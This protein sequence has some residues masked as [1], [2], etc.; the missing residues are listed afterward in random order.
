M[1]R[2][3]LALLLTFAASASGAAP[4]IAS[5]NMCTDQLLLGLADPGQI[6]GI[7]HLS[8]E[9]SLSFYWREAAGHR[10]LSGKAEDVL[11]LKPDVVLTATLVRSYTRG[12][13]AMQGLR[14]EEFA[15]ASTIA[16]VRAQIRRAGAL[17]GQEA[18]AE[19]AITRIDA[20]LA[21]LK[22]VAA[23]TPVRVL[24]LERR[25]WIS[26]RDSLLTAL[27]VEAGISNIGVEAT[28]DGARLPLETIITLKPDALLV[29]G[30]NGRAEDQGTALLHHP[31]LARA[32]RGR[33]L[34]VLDDALT[35]CAGPMLAEALD[36]LARQIARLP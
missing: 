14:V 5:I 33:P 2:A 8:R 25:G 18:R 12:L 3:F 23:R 13:L 15:S 24:P 1:R 32:L 26:G 17:M 6:V 11:P 34:L 10:I 7:S 16:E 28:G 36:A 29:S 30:H 20:A 9:R 31:A 21:R 35:V 27:L 19:A 22:A 4:R